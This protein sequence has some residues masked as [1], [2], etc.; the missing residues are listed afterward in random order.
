MLN[1]LNKRSITVSLP[2]RIIIAQACQEGDDEDIVYTE[3][4]M[5]SDEDILLGV[6][7]S[8]DNLIVLGKYKIARFLVGRKGYKKL[9]TLQN[10]HFSLS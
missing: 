8:N 1:E 4:I 5:P 2:F 9:L 10:D 6:H 3:A 7:I